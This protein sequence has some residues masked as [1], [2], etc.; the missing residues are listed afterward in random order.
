VFGSDIIDIAIAIIF[1]FLLTSMICSAA[2][3]GLESLLKTRALDLQRGMRVLLNDESGNGLTKALYAHP[4]ISCLYRGD[5][6][7]GPLEK[8]PLR[9][10]ASQDLPSYIPAQNFSA[11]LLDLVARGKDVDAPASAGPGAPTLTLDRVRRSIATLDNPQVQ[12]VLLTSIDAAN[13]DL[14]KA[15]ANIETWFN[16]TMDRVSGWYKRRTQRKL[17]FI[18]LFVAV[19]ANIN[20]IAIA[21]RLSHDR[22]LRQTIVA[23]AEGV[24]KDSTRR[25]ADIAR[26]YADLQSLSLPIGWANANLGWPGTTYTVTQDV[27][28]RSVQVSM[29]R[30]WW[31]NVFSP[32]FGWL[33]TALAVTLGSAFWFDTLNRVMSVRSTVKPNDDGLPDVPAPQVQAIVMPPDAADRSLPFVPNAWAEGDPQSGTL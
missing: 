3:E 5:Y 18:G 12:R 1:V 24:A 4:L 15:Q 22:T 17:F 23:D 33:L 28:G 11:A 6:D 21:E 30:G 27:N 16:N 14:A 32:L 26:R 29:Q 8:N 7:S 2:Q 20:I 19:A 10:P 25:M 9:M 31:D 13:G